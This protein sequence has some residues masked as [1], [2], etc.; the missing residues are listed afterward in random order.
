[1]NNVF[2]YCQA[3]VHGKVVK[4]YKHMKSPLVKQQQQTHISKNAWGSIVGVNPLSSHT[5]S[6][7]LFPHPILLKKHPIHDPSS[8]DEVPLLV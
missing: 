2:V 4:G 7:H 3:N 6:P 8:Y 1:M 5:S